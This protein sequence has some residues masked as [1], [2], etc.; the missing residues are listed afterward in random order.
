MQ[1][2]VR[3][4]QIERLHNAWILK[5]EKIKHIQKVGLKC[6]EN[7]IWTWQAKKYKMPMHIPCYYDD[8][9]TDMCESECAFINK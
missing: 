2:C 1:L 8:V 5:M 7:D 4:I 6:N 3:R 9:G